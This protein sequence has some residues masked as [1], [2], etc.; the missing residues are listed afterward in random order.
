MC[1]CVHVRRQV[2]GYDLVPPQPIAGGLNTATGQASE[3]AY[4]P[5]ASGEDEEGRRLGEQGSVGLKARKPGEPASL[6]S[7]ARRLHQALY[8]ETNAGPGRRLGVR[9]PVPVP[10]GQSPD[11]GEHE[12]ALGPAGGGCIAEDPDA[13]GPCAC[14]TRKILPDHVMKPM[15]GIV[16]AK[17]NDDGYVFCIFVWGPLQVCGAITVHFIFFTELRAAMCL[18]GRSLKTALVPGVSV[19]LM[20]SVMAT[21][22]KVFQVGLGVSAY[23]ITVELERESAPSSTPHCFHS[24]VLGYIPEDFSSAAC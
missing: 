16:P 13:D 6:G 7:Y 24:P 4:G 18:Q 12:S 3:A 22:K 10:G 19:R 11:W 21:V 5:D 8:T 20:V 2:F 9:D 23:L 17:P 15:Y 14:F 1:P